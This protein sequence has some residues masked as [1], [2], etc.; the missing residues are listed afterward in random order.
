MVYTYRRFKINKNTGM[1]I[2][3]GHDYQCGCRCSMGVWFLCDRHI[4]IIEDENICKCG[5]TFEEHYSED[6]GQS[7]YCE[8][9]NCHTFISNDCEFPYG[10]EEKDRNRKLLK[11]KK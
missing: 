1:E 6:G 7:E 5:H 10:T 11:E 4:Q 8:Q 3:M 2:K 9:C